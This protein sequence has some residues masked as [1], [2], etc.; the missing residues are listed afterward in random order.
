MWLLIKTRMYDGRV[1]WI[2]KFTTREAAVDE[3]VRIAC[4]PWG[5]IKSAGHTE[6]NIRNWLRQSDSHNDSDYR[7][8]IVEIRE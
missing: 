2:K 8:T 3:S 5:G 1:E 4:E 6:E 7:E